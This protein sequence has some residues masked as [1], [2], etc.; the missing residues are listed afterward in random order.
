MTDPTAKRTR[1][2]LYLRVSS[3]DQRERQTIKTQ[4]D[5]LKR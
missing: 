1:V 3:D 2:A 4:E 5:I